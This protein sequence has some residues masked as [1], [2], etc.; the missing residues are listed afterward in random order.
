M[1]G[2]V[3]EGFLSIETILTWIV[4]VFHSEGEQARQNI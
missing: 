1:K 2:R 3:K 4:C